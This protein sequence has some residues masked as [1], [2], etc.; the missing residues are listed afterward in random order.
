MDYEI[1]N[2]GH[3]PRPSWELTYHQGTCSVE[4]DVPK[5]HWWDMDSF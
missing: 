5:N 4:D 3:I 2:L 1:V